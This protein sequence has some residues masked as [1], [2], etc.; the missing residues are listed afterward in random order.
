MKAR[1]LTAS[2]IWIF[3]GAIIAISYKYIF[4]PASKKAAETAAKNEKVNTV[5]NTSADSHY[6]NTISL[7]NDSFSGYSVLRSPKF[8]EETSSKSIKINLVDDKADYTQRLKSLQSGD[9][10]M[11]AFTIDALIKASSELGDLP[12]VVVSFIDETKGA[13]AMVS[14]KSAIP[15]IDAL[16]NKDVK[17]VVVPNSPSETLVRV[18]LAHFNLKNINQETCWEFANDANDVYDR[19]RKS[20]PTDLKVFVLWQPYVSRILE[21]PNTHVIIDSSKFK[22]FIVDVLVVSRDYLVKN[23]DVVK[24]V[25]ECYLRS[26]YSYKDEMPKV[27]IEDAIRLGQPLKDDQAKKLVDG[28]WWKNTQENFAHMGF[29]DKKLQHVEDIILNITDV[30]VKTHA[31]GAD[32][33]K[34]KPNYL[35]YDKVLKSL[36][37][38]GFHPGTGETVR[39]EEKLSQLSDEQWKSLMPVGTLSAKELVFARGTTVLTETSRQ[40][41]TELC[42]KLTNWPQYYLVIEGNAS[43]KGNPTANKELARKRS[44]IVADFIISQGIDKNRVKATA[45]DPK[46]VPSVSFILGQLPY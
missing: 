41:L 31:I 8:Q 22:G 39:K 33:T 17:F 26:L 32:P 44:Q 15:N 45:T 42:Q 19:Y 5:L 2:I 27:V 34:G 7:G 38:S 14:Y 12:A 30:L 35:Y 21:N 9:T 36:F 18:L 4:A 28:I 46:N 1:I 24:D 13:D 25:V 23:E 20:K 16:N 43:N 11:A 3:L 29:G 37:D 6:K 40:N 10:Q